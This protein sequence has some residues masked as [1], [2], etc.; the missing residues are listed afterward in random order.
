M[1]FALV[2]LA[3]LVPPLATGGV[4]GDSATA[5]V[6]GAEF[7]TALERSVVAVAR[8][9]ALQVSLSG[10]DAGPCTRAAPCRTLNRA[11]NMARPGQLVNVTR[12]RY[13]GDT[14]RDQSGA[15]E[16][17]NVVIQAAPGASVSFTSRLSVYNARFLTLRNLKIESFSD[18][19]P[20][21]M[22]C[23]Q[24]LTLENVGGG[25]R[26]LLSKGENVLIKGGWWGNYG[27][28]NEQD[29]M[30]GGGG[31]SCSPTQ[32]EGPSRNVTFDGVTIR[33]VFWGVT[34]DTNESHPDCLQINDVDNLIIRNS[35]FVRCGQVFIGYY[36][37]GN[38]RGALIENNVFAKIGADAY[39][40]T[41]FNDNGKPG[42]CSNIVFRN[43]TYD[44]SGGN[45]I[46]DY[47]FPYFNCR[48]GPVRVVNNIFHT[49]PRYDACGVKGSVWTNNV[50]ERASVSNGRSF[51]CGRFARRARDGD[52]RFVNR[53]R[54]D[55]RLTGDSRARDAGST[56]DYAPF[57]VAGRRRY[58]GRAPDAGA[59]EFTA[60]R[61]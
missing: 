36:G 43:N 27:T 19:W 45:T 5:R 10:S 47:G 50:Y 53:D 12:G 25:R 3:A 4:V 31:S 8:M 55:Y 1:R 38:L 11:Y 16:G 30:L 51:V 32:P 37:D 42:M 61:R 29:I 20:L 9:P 14:I 26:F 2:G 40:T 60:R 13:P 23:V 24:N 41:Q 59:Y 15:K 17:P 49:T 54:N 6:G 35:R 18:Y 46:K 21:D 56:T 52:A 22:R 58:Q 28:S 48:G 33:D 7:R 34:W 39:Y 57:D 44:N